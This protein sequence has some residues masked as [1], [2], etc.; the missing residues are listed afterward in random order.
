[1]K[2][3]PTDLKI[4][5]TMV[6]GGGLGALV[7]WLLYEERYN[8][9]SCGVIGCFVCQFAATWWT[10]RT[11][12]EREGGKV[13]LGKICSRLSPYGF[14]IKVIFGVGLGLWLAY[15]DETGLKPI[16]SSALILAALMLVYFACNTLRQ[17]SRQDPPT[18]RTNRK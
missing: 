11:P 1:M 9:M 5:A 16:L 8:I 13:N 17:S 6:I 4:A 15:D 10:R 2:L 3:D 18:D 14:S 7:G 12:D